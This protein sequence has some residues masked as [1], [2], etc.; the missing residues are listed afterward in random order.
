MVEPHA[1]WISPVLADATLL[2]ILTSLIIALNAFTTVALTCP[3][4]TW[5][6]YAHVIPMLIFA[7]IFFESRFYSR[8]AL[9]TAGLFILVV[10]L[11]TILGP[12]GELVVVVEAGFMP[13][14]P[15]LVTIGTVLFA[16]AFLVTSVLYC[17]F[18]LSAAF[19]GSRATVATGVKFPYPKRHLS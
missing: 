7:G 17:A 13:L 19:Q 11:G 12:L 16:L 9:V 18:G 5:S 6:F 8:F 2:V 14:V 10:S 3:V 15:S 4:A 1:G